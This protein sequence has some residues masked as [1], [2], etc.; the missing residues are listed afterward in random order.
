MQKVRE[1][2]LAGVR[3]PIAEQQVRALPCN[4]EL[5][6]LTWPNGATKDSLG[7]LEGVIVQ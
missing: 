3:S 1:H 4:R 2:L 7:A 5:D 6:H